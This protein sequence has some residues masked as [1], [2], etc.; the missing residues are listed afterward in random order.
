M[1]HLKLPTQSHLPAGSD[2]LVFDTSAATMGWVEYRILSMLNKMFPI[3]TIMLWSGTV[4][5]VGTTL[6]PLGWRL[7]DGFSGAPNLVDRIVLAAGGGHHAPGEFSGITSPGLG[8]HTHAATALVASGVTGAPEFSDDFEG[9]AIY[10]PSSANLP[11]YAVC[12][13]Y[14]FTTF[15]G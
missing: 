3:G 10:Y 8:Q 11:Y 7:C 9:A 15:N 13:I 6:L 1:L 2:P 5:S 4:E 14:K 12:Y